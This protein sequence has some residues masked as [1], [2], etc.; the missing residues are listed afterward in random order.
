MKTF[1][2]ILFFLFLSMMIYHEHIKVSSLEALTSTKSH[3]KNKI[4]SEV[5]LDIMKNLLSSKPSTHA[6]KVKNLKRKKAFRSGNKKSQSKEIEAENKGL[7][8]EKRPK[9]VEVVSKTQVLTEFEKLKVDL[10]NWLQISSPE[11]R[12]AEKFPTITLP[13]YSTKKIKITNENFRVNESYDSTKSGPENPP[14][15]LYF[16][17]RISDKNIYYTADKNSLQV[18]GSIALK[19]LVGVTPDRKPTSTCFDVSDQDNNQ[20]RLCSE[21]REIRHKWVCLIQKIL[22]VD[23]ET[24]KE[25]P[26]GPDSSI[27][28]QDDKVLDPVI[29]IPLPS[30]ECNEGWGYKVKGTDWECECK[31]GKTQSPIDINTNLVSR[32]KIKPVFKYSE[33]V[34]NLKDGEAS[35]YKIEYDKGALKIKNFNAGKVITLDGNVFAAKEIIFHTP[36]QHKIDGRNYD[37]EVEIIHEG[38]TP[39]VVANHLVLN[40]LF[41]KKPGVYNKFLDQLDFFNLPNPMFKQ[42]D[43]KNS[44]NLNTILYNLDDPE[45]PLWKDFSLFT[46]EGS[47]TKPPCT[48]RTI[49]YV[50][51]KPMYVGNTTIELFKEGIRVPDT[52]DESGNV[53]INSSQPEN[54]RDIQPLNGRK[55]YYYD[56]VEQVIFSGEPKPKEEVQGHYEKLTKKMMNYYHVSSE[57]PSGLPGSFVV[58]E[59]EALGRS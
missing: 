47:L 14:D 26:G 51:A 5:V 46:Y 34:V 28:V 25:G 22:G 56:Y 16:Y 39:D 33:L 38:E 8:F 40:I 45:Y 11:F 44:L 58:S 53:V 24:C 4:K 29:L 49:Q 54:Y 36:S 43:V 12:N 42:K 23:D 21:T 2:K 35:P 30:E 7:A 57:A 55:V 13:D 32:N 52:M 10:E 17:F 59:K 48:E 41:E 37:M 1:N 31:D 6:K 20:W 27:I 15:E 19:R 3:N 50:M 18:I 9:S